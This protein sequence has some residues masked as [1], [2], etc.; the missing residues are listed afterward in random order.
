MKQR[1][2]ASERLW[3]CRFSLVFLSSR[4]RRFGESCDNTKFGRA[5]LAKPHPVTTYALR[6][7]TKFFDSS[8]AAC[9]EFVA[10]ARWAIYCW[11]LARRAVVRMWIHRLCWYTCCSFNRG[12]AYFRSLLLS[13]NG[14]PLRGSHREL[15]RND[16]Q[17][18][19]DTL[20][21]LHY[22][23]SLCFFC[24]FILDFGPSLYS[25]TKLVVCLHG[26]PVLLTMLLFEFW[27]CSPDLLWHVSK[28]L[29]CPDL[30]SAMMPTQSRKSMPGVGTRTSWILEQYIVRT[31]RRTMPTMFCYLS[32]CTSLC[33][34]L[35]VG[36]CLV[37]D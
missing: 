30:G 18:Q 6:S 35:S 37:G 31:V 19:E 20:R 25:T 33:D 24:C 10:Y 14:S 21:S 2:C 3:R 11:T 23:R 17:D 4:T 26:K 28:M 5:V 12:R 29:R 1:I 32:Q 36:N 9:V 22:R 13:L 27:I 8:W 7:L 16:P 15:Q 34:G